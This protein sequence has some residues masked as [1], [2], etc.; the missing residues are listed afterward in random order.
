MDHKW[1]HMTFTWPFYIV[2]IHCIQYDSIYF[3]LFLVFEILLEIFGYSVLFS[4]LIMNKVLCFSFAV[5]V[6]LSYISSSSRA[7]TVWDYTDF[8]T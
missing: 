7:L 3:I 1:I 8:Q 5:V 4:H 2:N 6:L